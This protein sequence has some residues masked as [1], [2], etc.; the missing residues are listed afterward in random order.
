MVIKDG[1]PS[2][3]DV[4]AHQRES[5]FTNWLTLLE[6]A[7]SRLSGRSPVFLEG[8]QGADAVQ[9]VL[10]WAY[11]RLGE[12]EAK[13]Q[14]EIK[15]LLEAVLRDTIANLSRAEERRSRH[16]QQLGELFATSAPEAPPSDAEIHRTEG[17]R[18]LAEALD[19]LP[20]RLRDVVLW[21]YCEEQTWGEISE[22]LGHTERHAR[23]LIKKALNILRGSLKGKV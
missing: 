20:R 13:P 23:N 22:R 5:F 7:S 2:P 14:A 12:L 9:E 19:R 16:H 4:H 8:R 6:R 18:M 17:G 3:Q 1:A 15:A 21:R 10:I 11:G